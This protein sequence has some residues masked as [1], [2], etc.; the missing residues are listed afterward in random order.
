MAENAQLIFVSMVLVVAV[1]W[2]NHRLTLV[3]NYLAVLKQHI[4]FGGE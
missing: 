3:E 2:L 1:L 4:T